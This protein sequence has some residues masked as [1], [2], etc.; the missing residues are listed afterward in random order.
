MSTTVKAAKPVKTK[1]T[2]V[3]RWVSYR[4]E[5]KI[6]DCTIRDGGLMNNHHFD[7]QIV[8]AV[9]ATCVEVPGEHGAWK[10]CVEEDIRRIIGENDTP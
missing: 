2:P 9:Y 4:P 6:V 3:S 10:Y 5:I 7:D 1:D 8:K